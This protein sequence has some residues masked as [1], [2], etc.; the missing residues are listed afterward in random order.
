MKRKPKYTE[1]K[2]QIKCVRWYKRTFTTDDGILV[3]SL[4]GVPLSARQR[5]ELIR[6][7]LFKGTLDLQLI[8]KSVVFIEMKRPITYK[9]SKAT[10]KRIIKDSGGVLS[11][12]Q[13][14]FMRI[15]DKF[16]HPCY[17]VDT[18]EQ[19]KIIVQSHI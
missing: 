16:G 1:N 2:L 15:A 9:T 18:F 4:N 8:C 7:G 19:F 13:K 3:A 17:V 5:A 12:E 6:G 10:G 14:D 11:P